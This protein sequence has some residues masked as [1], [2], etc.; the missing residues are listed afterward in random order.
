MTPSVSRR[1]DHVCHLADTAAKSLCRN[2]LQAR[3]SSTAPDSETLTWPTG[4]VRCAWCKK[5]APY[6]SPDLIPV[7]RKRGTALMH[8]KCAH[9]AELHDW[10]NAPP[11][12]GGD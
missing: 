11:V 5:I 8:T 12:H 1:W 3:R 4:W 9:D 10:A 6:G 2:A 7:K